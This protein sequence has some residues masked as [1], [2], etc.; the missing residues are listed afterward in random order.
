MR[1]V[2]FRRAV[3]IFAPL[4][5]VAAGIMYLLYRAETSAAWSILQTEQSDLVELGR[6]RVAVT[7]E[8]IASDVMYLAGQEAM[9]Q[10]LTARNPA[11]SRN[12]AAEYLA[13]SAHKVVY[14]QVRFF[15]LGGREVVRVDRNGKPRLTPDSQLQDK[16]DSYYVRETLKLGPGQAYVSPFDLNAEHGAIEQPVK[17]VIRFGAPVFDHE[18]HKQGFVLLNYRGARL[19]DRIGALAAYGPG[20]IWFLNS[21]GYWL[22]GPRPEDEWGFMYPGRQ[23]STMAQAYPETWQN[24]RRNAASAQ[25]MAG[26]DLFT[27][28]RVSPIEAD[29]SLSSNE[30]P[31]VGIVSSESW[32]LVSH[33]PARTIAALTAAPRRNFMTAF[34]VAA[35]LLAA[36][37][38]IIARYQTARQSAEQKIRN[39]EARFRGLLDASPDS[40]IVA[41]DEEGRIVLI[42]AHTER[43]FGHPRDRLIG[44]LVEILVPERFRGQ[45]AGHRQGYMTG[46]RVR[47]MGAGLD[48]FGLRADGTEFPV[49]ISLSPIQTGDGVLVVS[50]IRDVTE[51]RKADQKLKD[52]NDR[53]A[54]DNIKLDAL[55][56]ELE[57]FSYSVSHDLR[58]PL[59]AIDGFSQA[60]LEDYADRLDDGGRNY[61]SRVRRAAQRMGQLID[62]LLMLA[63]IT[64]ADLNSGEVD[65]SRLAAEILNGLQQ[66]DPRRAAEFIIVPGM[67]VQGDPRLLRIAMENLLNNA[68]KFTAEKIPARIEFGQTERHGAP[69]YVVRDNGA[70]FDMAVAGKLF[71]AFQRLHDASEFPGIGIGLATVQRIVSKHGGNVWAEAAPDQGAAFYFTL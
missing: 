27:Y 2:E 61:L 55:N 13:F 56:K 26:G 44:Q 59:R 9:R 25:F 65:L 12:L 62:D 69:V 54:Q 38:W 50:D 20:D 10:W 6:R 45:H 28:A 30:K 4:I 43:L 52:L 67:T 35:V 37:A 58:A 16:K 1:A 14:D 33:V 40:A 71:G 18:G 46:P 17:P 31:V 51:Q 42:N 8:P 7:L 24:I 21:Q 49:E 64:R 70:G 22:R 15:D 3:L 41:T 48:L 11:A 53:L 66:E 39:S 19:L 29:M 32:I 23:P 60:L 68:W 47:R 34:G 5:L 36:V 57:A 63:R